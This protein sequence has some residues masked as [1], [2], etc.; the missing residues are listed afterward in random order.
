L[1]PVFR[2]RVPD[3]TKSLGGDDLVIEPSDNDDD[4]SVGLLY[5]GQRAAIAAEHARSDSIRAEL[6][7]RLASARANAPPALRTKAAI[8]AIWVVRRSGGLILLILL[9]HISWISSDLTYCWWS[10]FLP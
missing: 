9:T 1:C 8:I 6:E 4:A 3:E 5:G 2:R 7:A 10:V